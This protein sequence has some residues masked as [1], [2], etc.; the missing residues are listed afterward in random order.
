MSENMCPECGEKSPLADLLFQAETD[1]TWLK[2]QRDVAEEKLASARANNAELHRALQAFVDRF[3]VERVRDK[4]VV[5]F[6]LIADAQRV[7]AA[8]KS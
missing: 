4:D 7:M 6:G 3:N 1:K 8:T 2:A 5:T